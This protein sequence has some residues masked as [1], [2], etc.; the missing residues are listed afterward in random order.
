PVGAAVTNAHVALHWLDAEPQNLEKVRQAL[1]RVVKNGDRAGEVINRI[2]GFIQKAPP[3]KSNLDINYAI[4]EVIALTDNEASKHNVSVKTQLSEGLP[5][6]QGDRVQ[7]Q[8]VILN[9]TINAIEAMSTIAV[10]PRD[11]LISTS[12]TEPDSVLVAVQDTGPGLSQESLER[13][14]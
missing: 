8:Q 4:R 6:I 7:L 10:G 9:L 11:L 14:F 3:Q 2:H 13:A 12:K 5:I 1:R